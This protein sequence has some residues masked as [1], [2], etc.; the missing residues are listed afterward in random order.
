ML[1][2]SDTSRQMGFAMAFGI[3]LASFVV[4][5]LLVP[6]V[7]ALVGQ[8]VWRPTAAVSDRIEAEEVRPLVHA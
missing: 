3:L 7:T 8:H 1:E 2:S 6:A 5:T 4:S